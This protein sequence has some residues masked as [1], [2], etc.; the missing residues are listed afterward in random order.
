MPSLN[1]E[2]TSSTT[3]SHRFNNFQ[4]H[5][6]LHYC[7][8]LL[9]DQQDLLNFKQYALH[10]QDFDRPFGR[11]SGSNRSAAAYYRIVSVRD[12]PL[13]ISEPWTNWM[14]QPIYRETRCRHH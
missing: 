10:L 14:A 11:I 7:L 8:L 1:L 4:P 5:T 6:N 9:L 13:S 2:T 12:S 3:A